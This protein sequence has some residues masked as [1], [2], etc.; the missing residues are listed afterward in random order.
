M[1][2]FDP[3]AKPRHKL[4]ETLPRHYHPRRKAMKQTTSSPSCPPHTTNVPRTKAGQVSSPL[5]PQ[6]TEEKSIRQNST[7]QQS[8]VVTANETTGHCCC[9]AASFNER[10]N[11]R[12]A[13]ST[14]STIQQSRFKQ[15]NSKR[16]TT[17]K[18]HFLVFHLFRSLPI[19]IMNF[20]LTL[21]VPTYQTLSNSSFRVQ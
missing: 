19:P 16:S 12:K 2:F 13:D 9:C 8:Y 5:A 3:R 1:L 4:M 15:H 20:M 11:K 14:A 21:H 7:Q 18:N 10:Q 6:K 17:S